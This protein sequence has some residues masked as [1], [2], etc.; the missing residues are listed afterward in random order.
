MF[1]DVLS[2]PGLRIQMD[3]TQIRI[4]LLKKLDSDLYVTQKNLDPNP[5]FEKQPVSESYL[6]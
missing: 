2:Y 6:N 5:T 3:F 1:L 4:L